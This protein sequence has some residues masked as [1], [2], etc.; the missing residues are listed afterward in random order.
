MN[1]NLTCSRNG[2]QLSLRANGTGIAI[3]GRANAIRTGLMVAQSQDPSDASP[4]G[5]GAP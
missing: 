4:T 3:D 2:W 1:V 5:A